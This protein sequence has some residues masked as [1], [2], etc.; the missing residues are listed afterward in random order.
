MT[1]KPVGTV[2]HCSPISPNP[3]TSSDVCFNLENE[4]RMDLEFGKLK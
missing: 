4:G 2:Q 1:A 3:D